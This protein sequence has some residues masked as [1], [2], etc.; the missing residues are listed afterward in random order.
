[1][2]F[3]H[4]NCIFSVFSLE[5]IEN[6]WTYKRIW[7]FSWK[8]KPL[9]LEGSWFN[10]TEIKWESYKI[11]CIWDLNLKWNEKIEILKWRFSWTYSV[12]EIK[13]HEWI[14]L[15]TTKILVVKS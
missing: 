8:I 5:Y 9:S 7:D 10:L 3:L 12:K 2:T 14:Y 15:K 11:T 1:M 13:K 4:N 6:K